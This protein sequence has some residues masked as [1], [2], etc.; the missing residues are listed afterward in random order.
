MQTV[1]LIAMNMTFF[2][3]NVVAN[4]ETDSITVVI[5]G[6]NI[7]D[8]ESIAILQKY[9]PSIV[10]IE[11]GVTLKIPVETKILDQNIGAI[12]AGQ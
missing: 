8:S 11:V 3:M 1:S 12:F 5:A 4:L 2:N 6:F 9:I 7:T 10:A